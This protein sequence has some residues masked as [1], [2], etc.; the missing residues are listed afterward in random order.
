MLGLVE[1]SMLLL[2]RDEG[3]SFVRM[4][5]AS[6]R[7][8]IA[9]AVLTELFDANRVDTDRQHLF[10]VDDAPTGDE[11]LDPT[12]AEIAAAERQHVRYWIQHVAE[13]ADVIRAGALGR[14]I[15]KGIL[16]ERERRF[17]R[18]FRTRQYPSVDGDVC[19]EVRRRVVAVLRSDEFAAPRDVLL[20]CLADACGIFRK[21]LSRRERARLNRRIKH[22]AS[23]ILI[24]RTMAQEIVEVRRAV[25]DSTPTS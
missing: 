8:A 2:L 1:E 19:Q 3:G 24:G 12:L 25:V 21:L 15:G 20:I 10:L 11:L 6:M 7:L 5:T 22:V 13:R 16:T 9:G 23:R 4:P 18:M 14:L 17:L